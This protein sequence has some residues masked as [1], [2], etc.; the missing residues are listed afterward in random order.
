MRLV[1]LTLAIVLLATPAA[2]Q[3][4][5]SANKALTDMVT[6]LGGDEF[7]NTREIRTTGRFFTFQR[8]ELSGGDIFVD[9]IKLPDM[10]RTEFG[11]KNKSIQINVADSGWTIEGKDGKEVEPQ[12]AAAAKEFAEDFK[13]SFDYVIRYVLKHPATTIQDLGTQVIDFKRTDVVELRDN[14]KNLIRF[15]IDRE[16]HLPLKMQVRRANQASIRE[17]V[18]ANWHRLDGLMTPLFVG[19]YKDGLKTMEIRVETAQYDSG[20][21]DE[22]FTPPASK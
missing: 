18:F 17:E 8:G 6:A 16:T 13:T 22:L 20:L 5:A 2:A 9:Y 15:Y 14:A 1:H 4:R 10:E 19:R 12:A 11:L 7:L 21:P 3:T